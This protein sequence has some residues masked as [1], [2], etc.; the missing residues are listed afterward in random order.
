MFKLTRS[1]S[2]ALAAIALT[3]LVFG[4]NR[5]PKAKQPTYVVEEEKTTLSSVVHVADPKAASQL[6]TGFY[7][8]EQGSWRW[9]GKKFSVVL[10]I[11][12]NV[13]QKKVSLVFKMAVPEPVIQQLKS[14]TLTATVNGTALPPETYRKAGEYVFTRDV[15]A[16][17]LG[18]ASAQVEFTLDKALGPVGNDSRELGLVATSIGFDW[19]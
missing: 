2:F 17:S 13:T 8:I 18:G 3:L 1:A 19:K 12:E 11:P 9:T 7:D 6:L 4:C 15:D 14:V 5:K 16:K 10:A